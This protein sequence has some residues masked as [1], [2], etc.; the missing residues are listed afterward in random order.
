M[1][2]ELKHLAPYL[3]Y[4]LKAEMLDYKID[5]VG[6]QYDEI[7]GLHQ[8]DKSGTLWCVFTDGGS[9]PSLND[10]KPILKSLQKF[11]QDEFFK[12][13]DFIGLG[14]WCDAYDEYFTAWFDD[15]ANVDKLILQ[16][17]YKVIQ[18]FFLEHYDVFGL[19]DAGLAVELKD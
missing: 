9:K 2:L 19:I 1:K 18:F 3:P 11:D 13:Q 6:R 17:P 5:Y 16:A 12:L 4:K 7:I 8:W 14:N 10:I 15:A